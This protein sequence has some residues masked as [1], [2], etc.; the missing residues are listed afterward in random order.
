M[1][2][3]KPVGILTDQCTSIEA[4]IR[5]VLGPDTVHRYCSWHILHKLPSK[6]GFVSDKAKDKKGKSDKVQPYKVK[7]KLDKI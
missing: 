4:S 1:D 7:V 3:V 5:H 6:W 2:G